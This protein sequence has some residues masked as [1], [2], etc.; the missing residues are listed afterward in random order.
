VLHDDLVELGKARDEDSDEDDEGSANNEDSQ[1]I[2]SSSSKKGKKSS[3]SSDKLEKK[4]KKASNTDYNE[5]ALRKYELRKLRYYFAIVQ[6]D[7]HEA[8][9]SLYTQLGM[10]S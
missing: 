1:V 8:A 10:D 7:D 4:V 5:I 6:C 9:N 3:S 2:K